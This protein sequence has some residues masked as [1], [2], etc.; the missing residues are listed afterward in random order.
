MSLHASWAGSCLRAV[1]AVGTLLACLASPAVAAP[2]PLSADTSSPSI[3]S[4]YGSGHFGQW[5]V[6]GFGLPAYRYEIDEQSNPIAQ[7]PELAGKTRAQHQ[8]GNDHI[9]AAAFNDGYTQL[10]SQDRLS[11]WAN[12]YQPDRQHYAGG[13]GWLNVGG[14]V[15]SGLYLDRPASGPFER[16]FGVGYYHRRLSASGLEVTETVYAPFGDDPVL[17][18]DVTISNASA[19]SKRASWF[20][21]WDVNPYDQALGE[22]GNRAVGRPTWDPATSTLSVTQSGRRGDDDAPLSIFGA[23]ILGP[24][25]GYETSVQSF[26][27]NGTRAAPAEVAADHLAG[28]LAPPSS[29]GNP[30]NALFAFRAPLKLAPGQTVTL[31]YVYGMA[32]PNQIAG[33]VSKYRGAANPYGASERAWASWLPKADFGAMLRWVSRELEWDAYL[34]R[35][36]SVYE[37]RCGHHTITQGGYYQY[38][39]G[40]NLGF[41]SWPHYMLPIAYADP[42]LAREILRYA[43][44]LQPEGTNQFP[45]GTGALCERVDLGTSNDLDFWLLLAA[46]EY[47][48]GSRDTSFFDQQLPFY[49]LKGTASAWDH[50]KLAYRHQEAMLGPHGG[51]ETAAEGATGDWSDFS[52]E[53]LQMSESMLVTAQLAYAY[54]RLAQLADLRGDHAFAAELRASGARNLATL[55][56]EWTGKGWYSRGYSGVHQIGEGVIFGEPQPWGIL[57]GAPSPRQATTLVANIH[58]FLDGIGAP[59]QVHGPTRIGSAI[60]PARNDPDVTERGPTPLDSYAPTPDL[61]GASNPNSTMDNASEWVGG[62]WFDVNGWL[63]WALGELDGVVPNASSDAWS[64]YTRNTLANHATQFPNHWDG[65]IS[66]DDACEGYY[67]SDPSFCGVSLSTDYNGQITEQATWMVMDAIRLAGI[68]PT[69]SGYRIAPHF[70]F[71]RFSVRLPQLGV[72]SEPSRMRGYLT[73]QQSGRVRLDV[74]LPAGV[75]PNTVTTWANGQVVPHTVAGGFVSFSLTATANQPAD[76]AVTW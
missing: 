29:D 40:Y 68:T 41:R 23:A 63:T 14:K 56:R 12:V 13:F 54:P 28:T 8:V 59:P 17:L 50:I 61:F 47:G 49:Y 46:S 65:T 35:S 57:A 55:R 33:L 38:F 72:A 1:V 73:P 10:W 18:E 74:K 64:E 5:T 51:Y 52:T 30:S 24:V 70:P 45:Y 9:V 60:V 62:T 42:E 32:H 19:V 48:L 75:N 27:G 6:D 16:D 53:F 76:W 69:E 36:A 66:V 11:Q 31:R 15:S 71:A 34:L 25:A 67:S 39:F 26:F 3:N 4:T 58:R 37:E 20:E 2:P 44:S 7:Q 21:Y 43:I 22:S